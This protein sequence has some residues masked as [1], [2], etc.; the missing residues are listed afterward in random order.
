M[1]PFGWI[2][3]FILVLF[4]TGCEV[5]MGPSDSWS[6]MFRTQT[7]S[8]YYMDRA[9]NL[10]A[11]ISDDVKEYEIN[12]VTVIDLVDEDNR[13]PILGQYLSARLVEVMTKKNVFR[14]AQKGELV[15][16]MDQLGLRPSYTYTKTELKGLGKA[17]HSEAIVTG[18]LTDLGTNLD[19]HLA[20]IDVASGEVIASATEH[21]TR[22]KFAVEMLRHY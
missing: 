1:K 6:R 13:A 4:L 2:G 19:A 7:D 22:T 5:R 3:I 18:R 17:L 8:S 14:V 20:L 9:E 12:K 21:I 11:Q 16:V 15:Q 10:V